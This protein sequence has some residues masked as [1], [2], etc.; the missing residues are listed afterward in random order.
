MDKH[1]QYVSRKSITFPKDVEE[2]IEAEQQRVLDETGY[3]VSL[4]EVVIATLRTALKQE[5]TK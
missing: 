4:N 5:K 2:M 1:Q 3:R